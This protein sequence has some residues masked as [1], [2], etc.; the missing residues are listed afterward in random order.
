MKG[1]TTNKRWPGKVV[2][3]FWDVTTKHNKI[4]GIYNTEKEAVDA[5]NNFI[6]NLTKYNGK[7]LPKVKTSPKGIR[8]NVGKKK[9]SYKSEVCIAHGVHKITTTTIY[10]GSFNTLQEAIDARKKFIDKLY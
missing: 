10:L 4:I 6:E 3:Q 2:A 7:V 9:T 8:I 5:K 1:I